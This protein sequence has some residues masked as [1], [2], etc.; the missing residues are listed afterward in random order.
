[1]LVSDPGP[2]PPRT[3]SVQ[4]AAQTNFCGRYPK[5]V[6][7]WNRCYR[8][9]VACAR[10]RGDAKLCTALNLCTYDR[11]HAWFFRRPSGGKI[12]K[13][14]SLHRGRK[15]ARF[16]T[17][18]RSGNTTCLTLGHGKLKVTLLYHTFVTAAKRPKNIFFI[19]EDFLCVE[20]ISSSN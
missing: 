1:M 14:T 9:I 19:F 20:Y 11:K 7:I 5:G 2:P 3:S 17:T 8:N 12:R 18:S 15:C 6:G 16:F 13:N 10:W 4:L